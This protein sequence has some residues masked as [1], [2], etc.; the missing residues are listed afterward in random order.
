MVGQ[1]YLS[2]Y[3]EGILRTSTAPVRAGTKDSAI[4][5]EVQRPRDPTQPKDSS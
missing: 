2:L 3:F 5:F 4:P 1:L